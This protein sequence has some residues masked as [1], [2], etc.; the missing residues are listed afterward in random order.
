MFSA[1]KSSTTDRLSDPEWRFNIKIYSV[2][3]NIFVNNIVIVRLV[4]F[5]PQFTNF[6]F[7][8]YIYYLDLF[9][10]AVF[11]FTS[12]I[13]LWTKLCF[14]KIVRFNFDKDKF[15]LEVLIYC[16]APFIKMR[17]AAVFIG[18]LYVV[19]FYRTGQDEL[20]ASRQVAYDWI[21]F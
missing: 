4:E 10:V 15:S 13:M 9:F 5:E 18:C 8:V 16:F 2:I 7:M 1:C 14:N 6:R 17:F 21:E 11:M 3:L 20:P 12:T 19:I